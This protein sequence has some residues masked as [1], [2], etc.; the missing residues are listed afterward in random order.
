MLSQLNLGLTAITFIS[1]QNPPDPRA[2]ALRF[3]RRPYLL[4]YHY[5]THTSLDVIYRRVWATP[6]LGCLRSSIQA[7]ARLTAVVF[8]LAA[9]APDPHACQCALSSSEDMLK[10]DHLARTLARWDNELIAA[11]QPNAAAP[12]EVATYS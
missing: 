9:E 12:N 10:Y 3:I 7:F 2:R 5:L 11:A 1:P 8:I 6:V 4:K